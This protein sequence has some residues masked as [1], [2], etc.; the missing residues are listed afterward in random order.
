MSSYIYLISSS[1]ICFQVNVVN[2]IK[3]MFNKTVDTSIFLNFISLFIKKINTNN[4]L[5]T[6][7]VW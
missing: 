1:A 5:I 3:C 4:N 6:Q 2:N 7:K